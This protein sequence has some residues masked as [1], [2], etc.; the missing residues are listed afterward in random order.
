[1]KPGIQKAKS[2]AVIYDTSLMD[3]PAA[4][5]FD[6]DHWKASNALLGEAVGRGSAWF[7]DAPFGPVV[8]RQYLRGGWVARLSRQSY[9]YLSVERSRPFREFN[10]LAAL[11]ALG[12]PV[13][14]PVAALCQ[15]QGILSTG[16]LMTA[17]IP[18]A[19]TLADLLAVKE[20][21]PDLSASHWARIGKCIRQFHDAGVWHADLNARNIMLD[22]QS[23]VFLI[24]FDRARHT[25]GQAVDGEGNLNRLK[26]S[27]HKLWPSNDLS[28]L[29]SAWVLLEAG[30]HD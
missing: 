16:A 21:D 6:A 25:P 20:D 28:A 27:L 9:L 14:R 19:K 24:D 23:K 30:Y 2:L 22:D 3:A 8:L 12:L 26:R 17:R 15:H 5:F 10:T 13:P 11:Y 18:S 4:D 7:I 1:M 29:Q